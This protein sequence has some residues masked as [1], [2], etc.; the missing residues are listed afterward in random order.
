[1]TSI[2]EGV[3]IAALRGNKLRAALTILGVAIGVMVVM[4]IASIITGINHSVAQLFEESGT[5]TFYVTR[6]FRAGIQVSDGSDEM[7]PWRR[8]PNLTFA[9]ASRL[10]TLPAV[11]FFDVREWWGASAE[12]ADQRLESV[13][14]E[15]HT[16]TWPRLA[17]GD[18]YP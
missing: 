13:G 6:Y 12:Y 5:R 8:R 14:V 2:F 3:G 15:G 18:V 11:A 17:G 1:M 10:G 4:A 16:E 9:E 7:S